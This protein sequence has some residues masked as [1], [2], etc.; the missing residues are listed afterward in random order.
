MNNFP[1]LT[2]QLSGLSLE[3]LEVEE[4]AGRF[5]LTLWIADD[6][7]TL[8]ATWYYNTELFKPETVQQMQNRFETL[9]RNIVAQPN[10]R[11]NELEMLS[12]EEREQQS[13]R[14]QEREHSLSRK[15]QSSKRKAVGPTQVASPHAESPMPSDVAPATESIAY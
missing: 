3:S 8:A 15:L 10:A 12:A 2:M 11:L 7:N 5:D 4:E 14:R 9:L 6:E 1:K 13:A